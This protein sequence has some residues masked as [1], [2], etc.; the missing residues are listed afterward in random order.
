MSKVNE[1]LRI[2]KVCLKRHQR[3]EQESETVLLCNEVVHDI[4]QVIKT[5]IKKFFF[6][7]RISKPYLDQVVVL[8]IA[9]EVV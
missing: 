1:I 4:K 9:L 7:L 2:N 3:G 6:L 5:E 8:A